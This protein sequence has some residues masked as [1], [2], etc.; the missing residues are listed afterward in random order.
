MK[1]HTSATLF[2][3]DKHEDCLKAN[4]SF[5]K[6]VDLNQHSL[7]H[8]IDRKETSRVQCI[9]CCKGFKSTKYLEG[10]IKREHFEGHCET[11]NVCGDELRDWQAR[12]RI[13]HQ[14][15]LQ[16]E[17]NMQKCSNLIFDHQGFISV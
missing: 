8:L 9:E 15:E 14:K 12:C 7:S 10:H 13:K 3:S 11:C 16:N 4:K 1:K 17:D 2:Y 6:K 5:S